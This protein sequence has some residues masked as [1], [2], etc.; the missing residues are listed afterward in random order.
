MYGV[1]DG[2]GGTSYNKGSDTVQTNLML[3]CINRSIK[4]FS[5]GVMIQLVSTKLPTGKNVDTYHRFVV[6]EGSGS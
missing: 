5:A 2:A 6:P 3:N 4:A 1:E